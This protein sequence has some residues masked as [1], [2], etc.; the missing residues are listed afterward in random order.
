M[1]VKAKLEN[2]A[3]R[4]LAESM[5]VDVMTV[6]AKKLIDG[7]DLYD[8]TGF[9]ENIPIPNLDAAR[10]ILKDMNGLEIFPHFVNLLI[11][12]QSEGLMGRKYKVS[13]LH[14]IIEGITEHGLI[15]DNINKIFVENPT[16]RRTRNWGALR[17]SKEYIFAFLR[18]DIVKNSE[19][20]RKYS[21]E[22]IQKTYTDLKDIVD[23][24]IERRNGRV[25]SWEGDGGLIAFYFSYKKLLAV[26]SAMEIIHE[27]FLYNRLFRKLN[28]PIAVRLAVHSGSCEY[29]E[30]EEELK[31]NDT[32]KKVVMIES[33]HTRPNTIT[34][35]HTVYESLDSVLAD[36]FTQ[37][38]AGDGRRYYSYALEWD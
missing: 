28:D 38:K 14:E 31:K 16:M 21:A 29:T 8:R 34:L 11:K 25:W 13:Y 30:N 19:L 1:K 22:L 33:K 27:L 3:V 20:V 17:K 6:L 18:L 23:I 36:Q 35:S 12:I 7:Y 26:V 32:V 10:Q 37:L 5:T 4:A 24:A 15:Y 2:L 9:P